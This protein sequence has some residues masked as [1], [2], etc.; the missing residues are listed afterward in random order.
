MDVIQFKKEWKRMC[1]AQETCES[2]AFNDLSPTCGFNREDTV[3]YIEYMVEVITQWSKTHPTVTRQDL[4]LR[5][6]P[7]TPKDDDGIIDL[8]PCILEPS[9]ALDNPQATEFEC[10]VLCRDCK[11]RYWTEII[12]SPQDNSVKIKPKFNLDNYQGDY[13]MHCNTEDKCKKFFNFLHEY[14]RTWNTGES[15]PVTDHW[16]QW[17]DHKAQTCIWFNEGL[18]G[19]IQYALDENNTILEFDDFDWS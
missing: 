12:D 9:M 5:Q 16:I 18:Y 1:D 10:D 17:E 19:D 3:E 15:Y 6:F 7:N 8:M 11:Y 4:L 2:C 13:V 14:G